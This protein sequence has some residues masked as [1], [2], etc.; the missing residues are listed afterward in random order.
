[1][2]LPEGWVEG[3]EEVSAPDAQDVIPWENPERPVLVALIYTIRAI[4]GRPSEFFRNMDRQGGLSA[5]LGFALILGTIGILASL[6]WHLI[7]LLLIGNLGSWLSL[8]AM[9]SLKPGLSHVVGVALLVPVVVM[10]SQ[11]L[12]SLF[13]QWALLIV[14]GWNP[15]YEAAF[16][17]IAYTH[18][19]LVATCIPGLGGVIAGLWSLIM[20]FIALVQVFRISP[21]RALVA[22]LVASFLSLTFFGILALVLGMALLS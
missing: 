4:L 18:A 12:G 16:R 17:V 9:N 13:L 21:I 7:Q 22:L 2:N 15:S 11:F 3:K 14:G 19:P 5:P 6:Y 1:M 10:V 20:E 8:G